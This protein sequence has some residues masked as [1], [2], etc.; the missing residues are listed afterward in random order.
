MGAV[1]EV[2]QGIGQGLNWVLRIQNPNMCT[3]FE[4]A[5]PSQ[6][7]A[8]EWMSAIKETAQSA[9]ARVITFKLF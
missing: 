3:A 5:V 6:E 8:M 1:V 9:S 2:A 4:V 7:Q